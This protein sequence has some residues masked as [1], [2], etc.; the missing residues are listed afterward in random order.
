MSRYRNFCFTLNNPDANGGAGIREKLDKLCN[1]YVIGEETGAEGTFHWQGY[2]ELKRQTLAKS[3][4]SWGGWHCEARKGTAAQ[5]ANYCK[6]DGKFT[7]VGTISAPG[8]RTDIMRLKELAMNRGLAAV[9]AEADSMQQ[10]RLCE[11]YMNY[12]MPARDPNVE[13]DVIYIWGPSGV[14]K[15]RKAYELIAD[16]PYYV[17]DEGPWWTGY[18]GEQTVLMDDFRDSWMTHNQFIKLIDRYPMRVKIH[19]GL[20]QMRAT[21]F[22]ITSVFPPDRLYASVPEEPRMQVLRRINNIYN[23]SGALG[24]DSKVDDSEVTPC[25]EVGVILCP[26]SS[27]I[28]SE[29]NIGDLNW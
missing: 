26:T 1:Y 18:N 16:K 28:F 25:S 7:E 21:R 20:T 6:K 3:V 23:M 27:E 12:H 13:I 2:A 5:A 4:H 24:V 14:G 9:A 15:S 29:R 11:V 8:T 17:K 19:G 22:I 10:F